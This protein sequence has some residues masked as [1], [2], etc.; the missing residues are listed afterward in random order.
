MR[1]GDR[2]IQRTSCECWLLVIARDARHMRYDVQ[3]EITTKCPERVMVVGDD[4]FG[5][6]LA[7]AIH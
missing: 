7:V 6:K 2:K 3:H 5:A 1:A 4:S